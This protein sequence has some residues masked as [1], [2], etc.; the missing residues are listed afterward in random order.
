MSH[1]SPEVGAVRRHRRE[2]GGVHR[3]PVRLDVVGVAVAPEL[4]VGDQHLGP[5]LADHLD[6]VRGR[7]GEVGVP[8]RVVVHLVGRDRVAVLVPLHPGVA[9][10]AEA[11]EEPVVGDAELLHGELEL[12]APV[13][14]EPVVAIGGQVLE[15]GHQDLAHLAGRAGDQR[16]AAA[17]CDVLGHRGALPD[18]LVVGVGVDQQQPVVGGLAHDQKRNDGPMRRGVLLALPLLL[19]ATGLTGCGLFDGS[20][21]P[22]RRAGVDARLPWTEWSSSTGPPRSSD[23]VWRT[24]MRTRARTRSTPISRRLGSFPGAPSWTCTSHGCSGRRR[25]APWT[26]SGRSSGTPG[27]PARSAAS[28][29]CRTTWTW[30]VSTPT[31]PRTCRR[32]EPSLSSPAST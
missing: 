2:L 18:R 14:P 31:R 25:S 7:L 20:V 3:D 13:L 6:Q 26:S 27:T 30:P 19:V 4:V 22:R 9:V 28:G 23:W 15:L 24:S 21:Q 29:R 16:D 5:D 11:A 10:G 12:A 32:P 8:E 1:G 17:L